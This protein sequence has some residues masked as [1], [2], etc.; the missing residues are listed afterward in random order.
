MIE[1]KKEHV[2]LLEN[3]RTFVCKYCGIEMYKEL[4]I[5]GDINIQSCLT[6]EEK[7]IKDILE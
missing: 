6:A 4:V 2:Y 5:Y 1:D 3:N 7:L